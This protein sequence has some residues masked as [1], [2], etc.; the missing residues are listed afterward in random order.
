MSR[1]LEAD[2]TRVA[3]LET[4]I[5]ELERSL[6]ALRAEKTLVQERLDSYKY[7][8]FIHFLPLYPDPPPLAGLH[9]PNILAA[10]CRDWREIAL[11]T[12]ALWRA[13]LIF[14]TKPGDLERQVGA[15]NTWLTRS[16]SC[17]L[18]FEV[19]HYEDHPTPDIFAAVSA[20]NA[21]LEYLKLH[22]WRA[23]FSAIELSML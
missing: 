7:P 23:N 14:S 1:T 16:R 6:S 4:Q 10:I 9:S 18:S 17:M 15:S 22:L 3:A 20:H 5:L 12:P 19:D 13:I 11:A 21:R 2:R 8:I